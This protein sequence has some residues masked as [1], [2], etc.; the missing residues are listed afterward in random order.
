MTFVKNFFTACLS[1]LHRCSVFFGLLITKLIP[2]LGI[3][4]NELRVKYMD[5]KKV[6]ITHLLKGEPVSFSFYTPNALNLYRAKT[7]STKEPEKLEWID[8]YAK[9]GDTFF[10]IGANIGLY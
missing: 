4:W 5:S 1:A 3:R 2:S 8:Q 6:T 10:D 7:F 9:E